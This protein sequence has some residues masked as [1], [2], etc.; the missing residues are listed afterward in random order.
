MDPQKNSK[1]NVSDGYSGHKTVARP[2]GG[3][4]AREGGISDAKMQTAD[5]V[6]KLT[7]RVVVVFRSNVAEN[8]DT[9]LEAVKVRGEIVQN[10]YLL[11][12]VKGDGVCVSYLARKVKCMRMRL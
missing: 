5:C 2:H 11:L 3:W 9:D 10:V 7:H 12:F 8:D 1:D 6:G 4:H